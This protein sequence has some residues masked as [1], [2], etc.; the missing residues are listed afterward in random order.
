[1]S[2]Q[3]YIARV[4]YR[5]DLPPPACPPRL[6]K[7]TSAPSNRELIT[8]SGI[9]SSLFRKQS[10]K[11][12]IGLSKDANVHDPLSLPLDI[13]EL[14]GFF[15]ENDESA[16][17]SLPFSGPEGAKIELNDEDKA[18]LRDPDFNPNK[19]DPSRASAGPAASVSFLRKTE[20]ISNKSHFLGANKTARAA[21][22]KQR[23]EKV[24]PESQ[25]ANIE[26]SF[27]QASETLEGASGFANLRHPI[28]KN[29]KAVRTWSVIPNTEMMDQAYF[30]T[31]FLGLASLS[32][33][34]QGRT[35]VE[36]IS[37]KL[38]N[39]VNN[40][41]PVFTTSIF[42]PITLSE[43]EWMSFFT[44]PDF[45]KAKSLKRK[46]DAAEL[47]EE[48]TTKFKFARDYDLKYENYDLNQVKQ[49]AIALPKDGKEARYLPIQ[50]KLELK[51]KRANPRIEEEEEIVHFDEL[52]LTI[53]ESTGDEEAARDQERS[54]YDPYNYVA[55][56]DEDE[57]EDRDEEREEEREE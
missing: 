44:V 15:D 34:K 3:D 20:Y 38:N 46:I 43:E 35:F 13:I 4:R 1:M 16:L 31:K 29:L 5:N 36:K 22:R 30:L 51:K 32:R 18:L 25:L 53:R 7:Y 56:L 2:R 42:K 8:S 45:S 24:D 54:R 55:Q 41:N 10:F 57:D 49:I 52:N 48:D 39:G 19:K 47:D 9:L 23:E 12:Y 6:L 33:G 28:K 50:G 21:A 27:E 26:L 14:P 37:D 40:H 17:R 11:K